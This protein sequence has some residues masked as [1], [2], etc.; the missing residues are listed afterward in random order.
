MIIFE[1]ERPIIAKQVLLRLK[2]IYQTIYTDRRPVDCIERCVLGSGLG[3]TTE[4]TTGWEAFALK[5]RWGGFDQTTWFRLHVTIPREMDGKHVVALISP[6]QG[7]HGN[8]LAYVNGHPAQGLDRNRDEVLLSRRARAAEKFVI[9]LESVPSQEQDTYHIFDRAEIAVFH[10]LSWD[11]YWDAK[12]ALEVWEQ[13]PKDYAPRMRLLDHIERSVRKVDLRHPGTPAYVESLKG[14]QR[15]L[16]AG[17]KDFPA[18]PG[19]GKLAIIG[20]SHIDTAWMWPLRETH[21]KIGRTVATVLALMDRYPEFT[22]SHSQPVQYGFL[23]K[24][25][26]ELYARVKQRVKEG[27]WDPAGAL[28]VE[29]D[30]NLSSGE[31]IIRQLLFGIRYFRREFGVRPRMAWVPDCFGFAHSLPQIFVKAG[32]NTFATTKIWW[33]EFSQFPY[34][35]FHWEGVDGT[36][37]LTHM[38]HVYGSIMTTAEVF[39]HWQ[40]AKQKSTIDEI[41]YTVGWGDGGGGPTPEIVE[42]A[43]R[44]GDIVGA[45]RCSF[46]TLTSYFARLAKNPAAKDLPVWNSELYLEVHR[47]CQTSQAR[48]KRNNRKCEVM[49]RDVEFLSTFAML[50]GGQYEQDAINDAWN[51]VLLNQFHDILPGSSVHEVYEDADRSYAAALHALQGVQS[52]ALD[53]LKERIDTLGQG[54]PFVIWNT[55]SWT[56][57]GVAQLDTAIPEDDF[58]IEG[59]TGE[60]VAHQVVGKNRLLVAVTDVPALGYAVYYLVPSSGGTPTAPLTAGTKGMENTFLKLTFDGSGRL[61][62]IYDK[63]KRRDVLAPKEKGNVLFLF[64]D[65]PH[66][67]NAWDIDQNLDDTR[68]EPAPSDPLRIV[69][70]GPLR[71]VARF[72]RRNEQSTITQDI[73]LH[74][75]SRRIDFVTHVDWREKQTMLK[76]AFPVAVRSSWATFE[77]PNATIE[78]TTHTNRDYDL[79]E[80]E[81][82]ALRWADL[83]EGDYGVSLLNDSKYGYDVKGHTLRLSLLRAPIDPDPT[84]DEGAH[85][86]TYSLLPHAGDWRTATVREAIDLN[87]PL[88]A[89]PFPA[90]AGTLPRVSS[91]ASVDSENIIIDVVKRAEDSDAS[92]MRLYEAYGQ[93]GNVVLRF[94][95]MPKCVFEC[96]LLEENDRPLELQ[97]G[98]VRLYVTPYEI[99]TLK[100]LF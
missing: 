29:P 26:P 69:E 99:R 83:S 28:F 84:A 62:R 16:R 51:Q 30:C 96:D 60:V 68:W 37:I 4:P 55:L 2:E 44:L 79:A 3:V 10:Q 14:A 98:A 73:V 20:H 56:R 33:G 23:Q 40:V 22:F 9:S 89:T 65:R 21:R 53:V 67:S 75:H 15:H 12:T 36:R 8:S 87:T 70:Q 63:E 13:L 46:D 100:V 49:L 18:G 34:S 25:Y 94:G 27:R 50:N 43:K 19:T 90:R 39:E 5:D 71:A 42:R 88:I 66:R 77:I 24:D 78:R 86:F 17:L 93:R 52:R 11:F 45:P 47:G 95:R 59:P 38:P 82:P 72:V 35:T 1:A 64:D 80:F 31:S 41:P 97:D 6:H 58:H 32:L 74:A 57:S 81:V 48:T 76:V 7:P 85:D 91:F 92:V 61:T 54:T